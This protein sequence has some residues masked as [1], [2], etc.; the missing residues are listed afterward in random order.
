MARNKGIS[1][2]KEYAADQLYVNTDE[3]LLRE[4]IDILINNAV[5]FTD[6]GNITVAFT[7]DDKTAAVSVKDT[8]IGISKEN[9]ELIFEEFRQAS[10]GDNRTYQGTG[11]GLTLAKKYIGMLNG[12]IKVES[13]VGV[14]S[15]FTVILPIGSQPIK[16]EDLFAE[17]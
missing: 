6:K 14:G 2:L 12:Q 5:K 16:R 1:I 8:G 7:K 17:F 9:I 11:L 4:V 15:I 13:E 10:E 3:K